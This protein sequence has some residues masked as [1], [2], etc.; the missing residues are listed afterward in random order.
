MKLS[1]K[2]ESDKSS[3]DKSSSEADV[4]SVDQSPYPPPPSYLSTL[5]L[6][7]GTF[8]D[9]SIWKIFLRPFPFLLSPVVCPIQLVD[10]NVKLTSPVIDVVPVP[11]TRIADRVA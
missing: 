8:T 4:E 9:E 11:D 3:L 6:W 7:H 5:K 2:Q 1:K 10:K